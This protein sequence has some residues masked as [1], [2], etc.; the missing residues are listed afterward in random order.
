MPVEDARD[1]LWT[2]LHTPGASGFEGRAAEVWR[3]RAAAYGAEVS[4]DVIGNSF[5]V[6]NSGGAPVI[7]F[8]GHLDEIGV[9]VHHIDEDGYLYISPIGGWDPQVLVAQRPIMAVARYPIARMG[10]LLPTRSE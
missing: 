5:A 8:V 6:F 10:F 1:F 2:L 9:I 4:T 3:S 7:L